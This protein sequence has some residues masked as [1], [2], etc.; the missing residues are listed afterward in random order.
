MTTKDRIQSRLNRSK[1][2]VFTRDDFRDIAG[3]DQVGRALRTLVNEGKLMK[4]GYGVYTKARRNV[5]TGK[6]MPAAPGGSAAVITEALDLLNIRYS[7]IGATECYNK[8]QSTQ[9]P[10]S[11]E[12]KT[13]PRFKRVLVVGKSKINA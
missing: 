1:R 8:G 9:I 7:L 6:I 2:Y 11:P 5:I 3:Y 13:P 4:V 10:V 12:F